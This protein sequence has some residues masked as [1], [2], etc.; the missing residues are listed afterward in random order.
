MTTTPD[1]TENSPPRLTSDSPV[2]DKHDI[3]FDSIGLIDDDPDL[4]FQLRGHD[5]NPLIDAAVPL[6]G[7]VM[8][9]RKMDAHEDVAALFHRVSNQ[10]IAIDQE[11]RQHGYDSATQLAYRYCLCAF[12]DEAV[13]SRPW[14]IHSVW[15]G[16][17][18]LSLHHGETW[19]GDKVFTLLSRMQMQPETYRDVLEFIYLCLCLGFKGK[20]GL[21]TDTDQPRQAV[22]IRLRQILRTLRGELPDRLTDAHA[23]IASRRHYVGRQWPWWSPWAVTLIVL[24]LGYAIYAFQLH[25]ISHQVL[26]SLDGLF[27][28]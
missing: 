2:P 15:T 26:Q 14:G 13:L 17:S 22:I 16:R 18:L 9:V 10:I 12:V 25:A 23:H 24:P 19:G 28:N 6:F 7:L 8:R 27:K 1:A 21:D 3:G 5:R 11:T 4:G 20:Y